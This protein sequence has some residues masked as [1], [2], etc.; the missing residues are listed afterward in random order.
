MGIKK[1]N[2]TVIAP[3]VEQEIKD[4][5]TKQETEAMLSDKVSNSRVLTDVPVNAKFTDTTYS[6]ISTAEIDVGTA[7]T[8]RV[9][10]GRRIKYILDKVQGWISALTKADIGLGSVDNIQQATKVE[11]NTHN[12]DAVRHITN[13]ER[14]TWNSKQDALGYTPLNSSLK[15]ANGGLA[16]LDS[17]GKVPSSQLPSYVD[18]VLEYNSLPNFPLTGEAGKIYVATDANLTYRWSGTGY[19]EISPSLALGETSSTAYRGDRGSIAYSHS[20][21]SHA[22]IDATK[23]ENSVTNG[24]IKING[25]ETNIYTHP[26]TSGS[27]HIPAGGSTGQYLKWSADGTA[28]WDT[29]AGGLELGETSGTAYRGDR[30][31]I[32]YD[33]SQS[34][35]APVDSI[36]KTNTTIYTP[37]SNYHPATKK[38]VD[39]NSGLIIP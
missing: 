24:N 16:E 21:S 34:S 31:K 10:T 19:V 5:Y 13:A 1:I 28:I 30:G 3:E 32:A 8:L 14:M 6:E 29:I 2:Y 33:H 9:I 26:T 36:S 22:R 39:D 4:K 23:V 11:F 37:T 27:K 20:Q 17:A 15:G 35:H 7:S 38:Y 12:N 25:V 18:D